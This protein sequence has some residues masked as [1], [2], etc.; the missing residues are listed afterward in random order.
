[1]NTQ[2]AQ[3]SQL[4]NSLNL[5]GFT[6]KL[7]AGELLTPNGEI[8]GLRKQSLQVL[9]LL[10]GSAGEVV[11]KDELMNAVWPD[12]V[13]G[14]GSLTQTI[15]DIRRVLG[16][17]EH[18][19]VK[20]VARRGYMLVPDATVT[21]APPLSIAVLPFSVEA[22]EDVRADSDEWLADALR[23]DLIAELTRVQDSLV[24]SRAAT[25]SFRAR[26]IDPRYVARELHVRHIVRGSLRHEGTGMRFRLAL[27][28]GDSGVMH[29]SETFV[30]DRAQ[31]PQMLTDLAVRLTRAL[32]PEVF[33]LTVERR[34]AL[35]AVEVTAEDLAMQANALWY[36]GFSAANFREAL[37]LYDR[38]IALDPNNLRAWAGIAPTLGHAHMNGWMPD[39]AEVQRRIDEAAQR[40]MEIDPERMQTFVART[41]SAFL[42]EDWKTLLRLVDAFVARHHH[43]NA[44]GARGMALLITGDPD[45][46]VT[47]LETALHLSARDPIRA[48]WQYRL[49]MAHFMAA[50]YELA[51]DWS[52][53]A[54]LSNPNIPWPPVHAAAMLLLDDADDA[55]RAFDEHLARHPHL[56]A[57]QI[58]ARLPGRNPTLS[59][60][61][62]RLIAALKRLGL[63]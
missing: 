54:E 10:G 9:L 59:E 7:V 36:R 16:D 12:V 60:A 6:L 38:A 20:N 29:W 21:D 44:F 39:R 4:G 56:S 61:R 40:M 50:R 33:R 42:R 13:V 31:M 52:Q 63:K 53:T 22:A 57:P 35:T 58:R 27:I 25:A 8:A 19:L 3:P 41:L 55:Q 37:S 62:E 14:E 47:A 15:A 46:A 5:A 17:A 32:M 49:A 30:L 26:D 43:P 11:S 45:G 51:S 23:G 18:R 2:A 24:I 1:M 34:A 28:N 48:E